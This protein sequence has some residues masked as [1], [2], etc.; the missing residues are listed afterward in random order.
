MAIGKGWEAQLSA[1]HRKYLKAGRGLIVKTEPP[2]KVGRNGKPR[3]WAGKAPV[4]YVG[5]IDNRAVF[6]DAKATKGKWTRSKVAKHQA[7]QLDDAVKVGARAFIAVKDC[8]GM[9]AYDWATG[10]RSEIDPD[11][12]WA[13]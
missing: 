8:S 11:V 13:L 5:V 6:F 9:W 3:E 10:E 7:K 2:V 4:D 12:G 1:W